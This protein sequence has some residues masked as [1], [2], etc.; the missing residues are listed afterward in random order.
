[1]WKMVCLFSVC[2]ELLL[3]T[4]GQ[5]SLH[6]GREESMCLLFPHFFQV[7]WYVNIQTSRGRSASWHTVPR[8]IGP[9]NQRRVTSRTPVGFM[10][11]SMMTE[12]VGTDLTGV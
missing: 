8:L 11:I 2:T 3:L 10:K 7:V 9:V 6:Q 12:P 5:E 4:L 1:M